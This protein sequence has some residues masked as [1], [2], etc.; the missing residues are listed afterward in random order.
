MRAGYF[1]AVATSSNLP[2]SITLLFGILQEHAAA[3][4]YVRSVRKAE[5]GNAQSECCMEMLQ[6]GVATGDSDGTAGNNAR[7]KS[8]YRKQLVTKHRGI[9]F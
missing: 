6:N 1:S 4:C 8:V 5:V 9:G 7:A 2:F 3:L